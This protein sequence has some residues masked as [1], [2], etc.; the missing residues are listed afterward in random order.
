MVL[1]VFI[2][3]H[4]HMCTMCS[5]R[6]GRVVCALGA[7][8]CA[9]AHPCDRV[10]EQAMSDFASTCSATDGTVYA[11]LLRTDERSED[12]IQPRRGADALVRTFSDTS[13]VG[14]AHSVDRDE[15]RAVEFDPVVTMFLNVHE[16]F[17]C[18]RGEV[19]W[20]DGDKGAWNITVVHEYS[21]WL[22]DMPWQQEG[23]LFGRLVEPLVPPNITPLP[24]VG[25][26][27]I[28]MEPKEA[29]H[30]P[31]DLSCIEKIRGGVLMAGDSHTRR[32]FKAMITHGNWCAG[33]SRSN[34][35]VCED[36]GEGVR[37]AD[38]GQGDKVY[39]SNETWLAFHWFTG[40]FNGPLSSELRAEHLEGVH[41]VV[42]G[43]FEAW[44]LAAKDVSQ[45]IQLLSDWIVVMHGVL[46]GRA[47]KLVFKTAPYFCCWFDHTL[48][49]RY[50]S[51]RSEIFAHY[52]NTMMRRAFPHALWW[53]SR[54]FS[55]TRS[56]DEIR[57]AVQ[58]CENNHMDPQLALLDLMNALPVLCDTIT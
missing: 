48:I 12:A 58:S 2:T 47:V 41:T 30:P 22:W 28:V 34:R 5:K 40:S 19:R 25:S 45:Y 38:V 26:A 17:V 36:V 21:N 15:F 31:Y 4:T 7:L 42:V 9:L 11:C 54:H 14:H 27:P 33:A 50:T 46:K 44:D 55:S 56:M 8:F 1:A 37:G 13:F 53:N 18:T 39:V 24:F 43:G 6:L 23:S 29:V 20:V 51:K 10:A 35:C 16:G 52:L 57:N 32:A 49:R 3:C